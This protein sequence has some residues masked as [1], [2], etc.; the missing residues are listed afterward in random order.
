MF[1]HNDCLPECMNTLTK[2][3]AG[4]AVCGVCTVGGFYVG[5]HLDDYFINELE[6]ESYEMS[7]IIEPQKNYA[8]ELVYSL[9]SLFCGIY[10]DATFL[11]YKLARVDYTS[12]QW[13]VSDLTREIDPDVLELI[14]TQGF[15]SLPTERKVDALQSFAEELRLET[16][17]LD[18]L[19][20]IMSNEFY[21]E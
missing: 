9:D 11:A 15:K 21:V 12:L 17:N 4:T 10:P 3:V 5:H 16:K 2:I 8:E 19:Q 14:V 13:F 1:M 20:M 18:A 6:M 7:I